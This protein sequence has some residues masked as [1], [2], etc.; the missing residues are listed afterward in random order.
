MI[1]KVGRLFL[2]RSATS[3][4][5]LS[6][7]AVVCFAFHFL[8]SILSEFIIF[9]FLLLIFCQFAPL[10]QSKLSTIQCIYIFTIRGFNVM[11]LCIMTAVNLA[12]S[13]LFFSLVD[14]LPYFASKSPFFSFLISSTSGNFKRIKQNCWKQTQ[15]WIQAKK[16]SHASKMKWMKKK[17]RKVNTFYLDICARFSSFLFVSDSCRFYLCAD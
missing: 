13:L 2:Y 4:Y 10:I 11:I 6:F 17:E 7:V 1:T 5:S 3:F 14:F 8:P 16:K 12:S 15:I 9:F